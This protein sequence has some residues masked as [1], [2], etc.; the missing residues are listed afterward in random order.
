MVDMLSIH[1]LLN[2]PAMGIPLLGSRPSRRRLRPRFRTPPRSGWTC[3][4][5][6]LQFACNSMDPTS[7]LHACV[8]NV[9][10]SNVC[11]HSHEDTM[12]IRIAQHRCLSISPRGFRWSTRA[13]APSHRRIG[14]RY[15]CPEHPVS[16]KYDIQTTAAYSATYRYM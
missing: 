3:A 6:L 4:I 9:C 15:A 16:L 10:L 13:A 8:R 5:K 11:A 14:A 7:A 12:R 2:Y 1:T